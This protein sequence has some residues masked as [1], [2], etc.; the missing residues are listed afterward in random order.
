[1]SSSRPVLTAIAGLFAALA[2][3]ACGGG[4]ATDTAGGGDEA[5]LVVYSGRIA[6][7]AGPVVEMFEQESGLDVD[8]RY[9][10]TAALAATVLEEGDNS[11]ADVFFSQDAG[12]LG[13][14]QQE[15]RL[16][17]L[18]KA[19]LDRVPPEFRSRAGDWVG[20]SARARILAYNPD[21][22]E[23]SELPDSIL[24][25]AEPEWRGRVGWAPTNGSLQAQLTAM[26][27]REGDEAVGGWIEAMLANDVQEYPDNTTIRDAVANGEIDV[28][29]INHYY[30]AQAVAEQGSDYP[31]EIHYL[32]ASD[33]G[34]LVNVAG[35]GVLASSQRPDAAEQF[36]DFLLSKPA[37]EYFADGTKEYPLV[38]GVEADPSLRPLAEIEQPDID[39]S[40]IDDLE[41][42]LELMRQRGAL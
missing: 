3:G 5:D 16:T 10:D 20:V 15:R 33:P 4:G 19:I 13:A 12:A 7:L 42:T 29:L 21:A 37:Q 14:L 9:G 39:L 28:G 32:P 8:V 30:V 26:R 27:L 40:E 6:D 1:M 38:R 17:E 2:L 34:S 36:V 23:Q 35:A 24:D 18:P 22:V 25:L 41:G 31:V 11:P